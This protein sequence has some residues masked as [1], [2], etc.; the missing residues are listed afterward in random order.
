MVSSDCV[1]TAQFIATRYSVIGHISDAKSI[2][3][4]KIGVSDDGIKSRNN[5]DFCRAMRRCTG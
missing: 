5:G 3:G 1:E 4:V 2:R